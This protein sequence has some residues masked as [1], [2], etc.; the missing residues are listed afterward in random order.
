MSPQS[1]ALGD[2]CMFLN[3]I[4]LQIV[5][6]SLI[7][8]AFFREEML[9]GNP[10]GKPGSFTDILGRFILIGLLALLVY[11]PARIFYLVE[12]QRL[13]RTWVTMLLANLPL[14]VRA[15]FASH[16]G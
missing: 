2:T 16:H 9:T 14:I 13:K 1:A 7:A 8:S 11:I 15:F 4:C 12:D 10:L 5:W 3:V 6:N